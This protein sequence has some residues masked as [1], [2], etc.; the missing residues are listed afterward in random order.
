MPEL[1][2]S[3]MACSAATPVPAP[4]RI[5]HVLHRL[6]TGGTENN[7]RKL[8]QGLDA[9]AF[10]QTICTV[11]GGVDLP[12]GS[13]RVVTLGRPAHNP[14][15]L[16]PHFYRLFRRERPDIV[17]SRNW[18]T[19][20]AVIAA[21]LAGVP[22]VIHSEHG[23]DLQTM[24]RAPWRR[25]VFRRACYAWA[26][27]VFAVSRELAEFYSTQLGIPAERL[28]VVP[29][30]VDTTEF[31]PR[32]EWRLEFRLRLGVPPGTLVV[33][34][35]SRLD[36][37][38]DH[39]TLFR[40]AEMAANSGLDLC[41]V[42]VGEG[43][44][45][46]ALERDLLARPSLA[47]RVRFIGEVGNVAEW[48]NS[49]D[50]FALPSLSEGMSNT[51]LEAMAVGVPPVAT[52]VG[53]NPEVI[54]EG[55]SGILFEPGDFRALA[56]ALQKM[57]NEPEWRLQLADN[58]RRRVAARFSLACMMQSYSRMYKEVS[59]RTGRAEPALSR[60]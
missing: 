1:L 47:G 18:G 30:G 13:A 59:R 38:K 11:V 19:I 39:L 40:A 55:C 57:A 60:T 29:N 34:A 43:V 20:E 12:V 49:F 27:R 14:G 52:C 45:R 28:E 10:E 15:F 9:T 17:H 44:C 54:G 24:G 50:V 33:G 51:L 22:A 58:C 46:P 5:M 31:R 41:L 32:P 3:E 8:L 36:P 21:R 4:I 26:G 2:Q 25:R 48:L 23:R 35:V 56:A 53:G 6:A 37:V 42:V 16:V 7:V